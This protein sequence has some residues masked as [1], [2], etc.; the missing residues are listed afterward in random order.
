MALAGRA[1]G[2]RAPRR[3]QSA[4]GGQRLAGKS[5]LAIVVL[6]G[7]MT[8]VNHRGLAALAV[9]VA[10]LWN[11]RLST[12]SLLGRIDG[13]LLVMIAGLF[14][15]TGA[16]AALP[17]AS[18]ATNWLAEHGLLSFD[19]GSLSGFSLLASNTIGNVP[20]V[21]LLLGAVPPLPDSALYGLA[22]FSTLSGNLL[23]I[24]SLANIIVAERSA[25]CDVRLGF[26]RST[27]PPVSGRSASQCRPRILPRQSSPDSSSTMS[28][29]RS[30]GMARC[31]PGRPPEEN[32][33]R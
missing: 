2:R 5:L 7:L 21:V 6:I 17:A 18:H 10:L 8:A 24:G 14:V 22:L 1:L 20:A 33:C 28:A 29:D 11:R 3:Q 4:A 13:P 23:I 31:R 9:A 25:R 32:S 15:I 12:R 27:R 26:I 16:V 30:K 19:I